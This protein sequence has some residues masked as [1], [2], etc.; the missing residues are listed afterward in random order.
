MACLHGSETC[1]WN[2]IKKFKEA[3]YELRKPVKFVL[4][5]EEAFEKDE[6]FIETDINRVF[7]GDPESEL[8]EEKLA[9]RL[10][11]ELEGQK[12]LDIHSTKSRQAPFAI[13]V[14]DSEEELELA[15][16]TGIGHLIDMSFVEG[17]MGEELQVVSIELSR[18]T[19]DQNQEA[20]K[21]LVNF[22][23]AEGIIE[24][25]HEQVEQEFFKVYDTEG[26]GNEEF[27]A[28]NFEKVE[29][30]EIYARK[31]SDEDSPEKNHE[32]IRAQEDFHPILMSTDG[33][34]DMLGFKA[35]KRD[36]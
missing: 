31:V 3:D 8:H 24:E 22:L 19:Q 15:K 25:E 21:L 20:Y 36:I 7:P 4:A 18:T 30:G 26:E 34:D 23:A 9:A 27:L 32:S 11:D 1:G 35:R 13:I 16:S 12:I 14:G 6:R 28:D 33:Y 2:A 5:N 10:Q 17:G 29:K